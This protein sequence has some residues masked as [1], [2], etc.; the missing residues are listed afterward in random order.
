MAIGG[1][2][3]AD[4]LTD[5]DRALSFTTKDVQNQDQRADMTTAVVPRLL[6][7]KGVAPAAHRRTV[8]L[9]KAGRTIGR[10][11]M[12]PVPTVRR[13]ARASTVSRKTQRESSPSSR[14]RSRLLQKLPP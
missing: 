14:A 1:R 12:A 13:N 2:L 10:V 8:A 6:V 11:P 9:P 4:P 7:L 3:P 5:M